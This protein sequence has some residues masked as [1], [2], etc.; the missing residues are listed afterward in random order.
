MEVSEA[1][2]EG[3]D[4]DEVMSTLSY[5]YNRDILCLQ[6]RD[7]QGLNII[8]SIFFPFKMRLNSNECIIFP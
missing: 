1:E 2:G 6:T 5:A 4:N 7:T 3:S 8:R